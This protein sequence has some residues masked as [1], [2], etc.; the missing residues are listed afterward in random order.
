MIVSTNTAQL[1]NVNTHTTALTNVTGN[2]ASK[3]AG[4]AAS[5]AELRWQANAGGL[6]SPALLTNLLAVGYPVKY[7][8]SEPVIL[9][10]GKGLQAIGGTVATTIYA[11]YEFY[12]ETA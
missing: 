8:F 2:P 11:N 5:I 9:P 4:G 10:P 6:G 1:V 12:E 7:Q 3:L